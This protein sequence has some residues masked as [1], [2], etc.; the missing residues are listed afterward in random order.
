M[1]TKDHFI[2]ATEKLFQRWNPVK[3]HK[4]GLLDLFFDEFSNEDFKPVRLAS[5]N[6]AIRLERFPSPLEFNGFIIEAKNELG[7]RR[8][9]V[10]CDECGGKGMEVVFHRITGDSRAWRCHCEAGQRISRKVLSTMDEYER[11]DVEAD[12][13]S[14]A[15]KYTQE[16][17]DKVE[18]MIHVKAPLSIMKRMNEL[19]NLEEAPF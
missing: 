13:I 9:R 10:D 15:S 18:K 7:I 1:M 12:V 19:K 3:Q 5:R 6:A 17:L 14:N 4:I 16:N 11:W 8:E 2:R